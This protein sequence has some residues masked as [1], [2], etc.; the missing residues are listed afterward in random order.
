MNLSRLS[1]ARRRMEFFF[2]KQAIRLRKSKIILIIGCG[3][4]GTTFSSKYLGS[5]NLKI[6]HERLYL[7]GSSSWYL[8][9]DKKKVSIGP[10]FYDVKDLEAI[11]I[12]QVRE[13]LGAISSMLSTGSPSWHFL[14][15]E[16]PI[17]LEKDSKVLRAMK[18]Y[19]YWN[20]KA[21]KRAKYLVRAETFNLDILPILK[22]NGYNIKPHDKVTYHDK[23][24]T[25]TH[26]KLN[27]D[28][29]KSEDPIL[30][31]DI[32]LMGERYGYPN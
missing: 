6:G 28:D 19:Y 15:N 18:Y 5:L 22:E 14:S 30:Y 8:V 10:S 26:K 29:L 23:I 12:H 13:P 1:V 17:N 9:S 21:E 11:I 31:D 20:L 25:R 27:W 7:N 4:S 2:V 32:R 24:N 3:R 16:I